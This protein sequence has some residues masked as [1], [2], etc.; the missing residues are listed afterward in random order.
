MSQS[1]P[2]S[3]MQ[4]HYIYAYRYV[5]RSDQ[6]VFHGPGHPDLSA[7][8]S[9]RTKAGTKALQQ[10]SPKRKNCSNQRVNESCSSRRLTNLE[11]SGYIVLEIFTSRFASSE[12][13]RL[14]TDY[15]RKNTTDLNS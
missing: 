3:D 14:I 15:F 6:E 9:P 7:V 2:V 1:A 11:V 5:C 12:A 8:G 4:T 10:A 13:Y